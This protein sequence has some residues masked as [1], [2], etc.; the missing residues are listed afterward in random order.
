[1]LNQLVRDAYREIIFPNS[2]GAKLQRFRC[3]PI[4]L[5]NGPSFN[6]ELKWY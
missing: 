5:G 6:D 1:M 2:R 3:A 4:Q